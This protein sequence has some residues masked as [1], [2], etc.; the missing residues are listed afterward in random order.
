MELARVADPRQRRGFS[1]DEAEF[2]TIWLADK[3]LEVLV[4]KALNVVQGKINKIVYE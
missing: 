2:L 3:V 4:E 1:I